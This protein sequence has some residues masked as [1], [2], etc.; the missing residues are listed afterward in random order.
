[1]FEFVY[2]LYAW[3][4][5]FC[6][7]SKTATLKTGKVLALPS[8][9]LRALLPAYDYNQVWNRTTK[10][11]TDTV[12]FQCLS[13]IR[14]KDTGSNSF[15]FKSK[16]RFTKLIL[17]I[18]QNQT[19]NTVTP[20]RNKEKPT[21]NKVFVITAMVISIYIPTFWV[22]VFTFYG[23]EWIYEFVVFIVGMFDLIFIVFQSL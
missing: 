18:G 19:Y 2:E 5:R 13:T 20:T 7:T 23:L 9:L 11:H 8:H 3:S 12:G 10:S 14:N 21:N 15:N 17:N 1:M 4:N 16:T 22:T 6:D